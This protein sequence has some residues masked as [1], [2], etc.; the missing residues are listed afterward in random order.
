MLLLQGIQNLRRPQINKL[1]ACVAGAKREGGGGGEKLSSTPFEA[2]YAPPPPFFPFLPIPY[3]FRPLLRTQATS[4]NFYHFTYTTQN[5]NLAQILSDRHLKISKLYIFSDRGS[6][7][8]DAGSKSRAGKMICVKF[9]VQFE[10][11]K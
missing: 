11:A 7:V 2:C 3:P 4:S 10:V 5:C 8:A 6:K 9:K 1:I